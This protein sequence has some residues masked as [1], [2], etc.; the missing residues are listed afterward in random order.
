[1]FKNLIKNSPRSGTGFHSIRT[2]PCFIDF[3]A[4]SLSPDSYPIEV[5]WST[6]HGLIESW[7]I[8]PLP[9]GSWTDWDDDV[10]RR[11]H[12]ISREQLEREGRSPGWIAERMN[13]ALAGRSVYC[14]GGDMD[15]FWLWRLYSAA[16][17]GV[18]YT[19]CDFQDLAL[20]RVSIDE[21]A[22]LSK[23]VHLAMPERHRAMLDVAFLGAL[24][25]EIEVLPSL[26]TRERAA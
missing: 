18:S 14:D 16:S 21:L 1:M 2:A 24:W 6:E 7:L 8:N 15:H 12:G 25:R 11:I 26:K 20:G 9:Q 17:C 4:S 5:A 13:A 22:A 19:I 23:R 10:E 3:E